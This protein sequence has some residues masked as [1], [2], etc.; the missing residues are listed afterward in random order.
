MRRTFRDYPLFNLQTRS[1]YKIRKSAAYPEC[2]WSFS[3]CLWRN[4]ILKSVRISD[5]LLSEPSLSAAANPVPDLCSMLR[6][7]YCVSIRDT[8]PVSSRCLLWFAEVDVINGSLCISYAGPCQ[9]RLHA[10]AK[11][12]TRQKEAISL[13][14]GRPTSHVVHQNRSTNNMNVE[15]EI[16]DT[17]CGFRFA[18]PL[19][20]N[21]TCGWVD[22][23]AARLNIHFKTSMR[24]CLPRGE[25]F[26]RS[27]LET[28]S[29]SKDGFL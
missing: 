9:A 17:D 28:S 19:C 3:S 4:P 16:T 7:G 1:N 13:G 20:D 24:H 22:L 5:L 11:A 25:S 26:S 2:L 8:H 6:I 18:L 14:Q 12:L 15:C 21:N 23:A 27:L 29:S 10:D